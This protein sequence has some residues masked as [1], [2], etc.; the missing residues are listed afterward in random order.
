MKMYKFDAINEIDT[1]LDS[2][3]LDIPTIIR[4]KIDFDLTEQDVDNRLIFG[5]DVADTIGAILENMF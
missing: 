1:V 2:E 5:Y 4:T 3:C